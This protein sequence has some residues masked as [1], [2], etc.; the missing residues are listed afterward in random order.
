MNKVIL[1]NGSVTLSRVT[2]IIYSTR[3]YVLSPTWTTNSIILFK[4]LYSFDVNRIRTEQYL[5]RM[6]DD[7]GALKVKKN[8][9]NYTS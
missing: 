7:L 5:H 6:F 4:F 3:K 1:F 8:G 2:Y 9:S